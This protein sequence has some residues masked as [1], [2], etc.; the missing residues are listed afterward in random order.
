[1]TILLL[2]ATGFLGHNVARL[3]LEQGHVVQVLVRD[4]RKLHMGDCIC[5]ERLINLVE[6]NPFDLRE[7]H[8]AAEG[9][10]AIINCIG[11][12]DM[13]LLR[14]EDYLPANRDICSMLT[15]LMRETGISCLVHVSTANTIGY[16]THY[17]P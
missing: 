17:H 7:L 12:T 14:Y 2:G 13:S 6:G 1:M 9:C 8:R 10:D 5:R 15:N 11:C 4:C 16:G 3:L